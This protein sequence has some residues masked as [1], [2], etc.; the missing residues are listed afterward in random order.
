MNGN[1]SRSGHVRIYENTGGSWTK[2]D[3]DI[4]GEAAE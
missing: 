1:G 3:Q 4:D 2:V